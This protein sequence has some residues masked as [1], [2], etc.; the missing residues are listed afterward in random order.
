MSRE[1]V[2]KKGI[3]FVTVIWQIFIK[4]QCT[5]V[6]PFGV[7]FCGCSNC[8]FYLRNILMCITAMCYYTFTKAKRLQLHLS[9]QKR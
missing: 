8:L 1:V 7:Y 9:Q 6:W 3:K 2:A 4:A 5:S